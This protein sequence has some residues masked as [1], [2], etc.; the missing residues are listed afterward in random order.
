[1]SLAGEYKH[2]E[3][4]PLPGI[5][6][7]TSE[8]HGPALYQLKQKRQPREWQIQGVCSGWEENLHHMAE[9]IKIV[10]TAALD[11]WVNNNCT[12]ASNKWANQKL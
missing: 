11:E 9:L 8:I 7:M 12:V 3:F 10:Y 5:K 4:Q 2:R 6:S 1:M